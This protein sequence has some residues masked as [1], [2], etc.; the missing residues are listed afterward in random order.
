MMVLVTS[1]EG[2]P[3]R[4]PAG[5]E[6][7][8]SG[9][10]LEGESAEVMATIE[11]MTDAFGRGDLAGVMSTYERDAIVVFEPGVGT[12]GQEAIRRGFEQSLAV[13]PAFEF[14][15]HEVIVGGDLAVHH[16]PWTMTGTLPDGG[17]IEQRGLSVAV[18]RR[19]EDGAW[20]MVVDNP[21]GGDAPG[22]APEAGAPTEVVEA[23]G[24]MTDAFE[25]GDVDGVMRAYGPKAQVMFEPGVAT[26]GEEEIRAGFVA[27]MEAK[28][29][30]EYAWHEVHVT[31]DVAVHHAPWTMKAAGE[32]GVAEQ[33]GLSVAVLQRQPDGQWRI[34]IDNPHGQWL[35][36]E[37]GY[38]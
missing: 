17:T 30:F 33:R 5:D 9:G 14:S 34:V 36:D 10:E 16:T 38:P 26:A 32:M 21:Y 4:W 22:R 1:C 23:V 12:R 3:T 27:A 13:A 20:L 2:E 25:R 37:F 8:G 24:R 35:V 11:R 28:P 19:Q 31:G 15:A 7:G 18:L 6:A 29:R